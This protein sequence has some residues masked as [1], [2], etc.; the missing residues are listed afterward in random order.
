ML[1]EYRDEKI[2]TSNIPEGMSRWGSGEQKSNIEIQI[3]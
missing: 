1:N 2:R 3:T